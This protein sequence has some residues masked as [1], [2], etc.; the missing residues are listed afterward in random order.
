MTFL[1]N[2][3]EYFFV[4]VRVVFCDGKL[5]CRGH[6]SNERVLANFFFSFLLYWHY[7]TLQQRRYEQYCFA[8][9]SREKFC[10]WCLFVFSVVCGLWYTLVNISKWVMF[11]FTL[12]TF[13]CELNW[14]NT[15][16]LLKIRST[17]LFV[18]VRSKPEVNK[19]QYSSEFTTRL[20]FVC[21]C[22]LFVV[23][24]EQQQQQQTLRRISI[25]QLIL[26]LTSLPWRHRRKCV[27][28]Q[29]TTV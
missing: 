18:P 21:V 4:V 27:L 8:V 13:S 3:S 24:F 15:A 23:E 6:T 9:V 1:L 29:T 28:E 12:K 26:T 22:P 16:S 10:L 19:N 7:Y 5:L 25:C 17:V 14:N 2:E 20:T 11:M